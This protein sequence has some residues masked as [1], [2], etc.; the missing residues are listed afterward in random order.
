MNEVPH[1]QRPEMGKPFEP[2]L[3][4]EQFLADTGVGASENF[5]QAGK[6]FA[7]HAAVTLTKPPGKSTQA[8]VEIY[9]QTFVRK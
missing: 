2:A 9:H 6:P 4:L 3:K 1:G 5:N 8:K 7:E